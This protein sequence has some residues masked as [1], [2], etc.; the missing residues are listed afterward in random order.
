MENN[1]QEFDKV[2]EL[3]INSSSIT[4]NGFN[5]ANLGS[6]TEY[7]NVF[8]DGL[9]Q[10]LQ[11]EDKKENFNGH[12]A[13]RDS[14]FPKDKE[15]VIEFINNNADLIDSFLDNCLNGNQVHWNES[16]QKTI[17]IYKEIYG[18]DIEIDD[19]GIQIKDIINADAG[20]SFEKNSEWVKPWSVKYFYGM[21]ATQN[22]KEVRD[23]D[24][25]IRILTNEN[26]LQKTHKLFKKYIRLLMPEY[27]RT[28][29]IE[30]LDRNFWVIG[31]VLS[32]ILAFLFDDDAKLKDLFKGMLDEIVQLWQNLLFLW[33][34]FILIAQ[35]EKSEDIITIVVPVNNNIIHPFVNFDNFNYDRFDNINVNN[36]EEELKTICSH[37][38]YLIDQY[39]D[40][41]LIIIPELRGNSYC[42]NY[43]SDVLYPGVIFVDRYHQK[44]NAIIEEREYIH[45]YP[46]LDVED[47]N[48]GHLLKVHFYDSSGKRLT[49]G[50]HSYMNSPWAVNEQYCEYNFINNYNEIPKINKEYFAAIR[51]QF[52]NAEARI[53]DEELQFSVNIAFYDAVKTLYKKHFTTSVNQDEIYS[54]TFELN[55]NKIECNNPTITDENEQI[56]NKKCDIGY[57]WYKG[58]LA[59]IS[60]MIEIIPEGE[61][62]VIEKIFSN[63]THEGYINKYESLSEFL[64]S[65]SE[66]D[67]KER[68]KGYVKDNA[69]NLANGH[70]RILYAKYSYHYRP[71]G[72]QGEQYLLEISPYISVAVR[73]KD[74]ELS[75]YDYQYKI[76]D[77]TGESLH[78][79]I[80]YP[81]VSSSFDDS[82]RSST[83]L[84]CQWDVND[85]LRYG[86]V[87][88]P[89]NNLISQNT[90]TK[91]NLVYGARCRE[92]NQ[93]LKIE[94]ANGVPYLYNYLLLVQDRA[95]AGTYTNTDDSIPYS[96]NDIYPYYY[97]CRVSDY[98]KYTIIANVKYNNEKVGMES[99]DD[100]YFWAEESDN[101]GYLKS[102]TS[103]Q[104]PCLRTDKT[105]FDIGKIESWFLNQSPR[106]LELEEEVE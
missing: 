106:P 52:S 54:G 65:L 96:V 7:Q 27:E 26:N 20:N 71:A 100:Y 105:E 4:A 22:Y 70:A 42:K 74:G 35:K 57:G 102:D 90:T 28:V 79:N 19:T 6:F 68:W 85:S 82:V 41:S 8:W 1:Y 14:M 11:N 9:L 89:N 31:H 97:E 84:L 104:N 44:T 25:I 72:T 86:K 10:F 98:T 58:E 77:N 69:S 88:K 87:Y 67:E 62:V 38:T 81:Y 95:C 63:F 83:E 40:S 73:N 101:R 17:N 93:G 56:L 103:A 12:F 15:S 59:T 76:Q 51:T 61:A 78:R 33:V 39:R 66:I 99:D 3:L 55:N 30:D 75:T 49:I 47:L 94:F 32:G 5:G 64:A 23:G 34:G 92:N 2:M 29:E 16:L 60:C 18:D 13:I 45:Y 80:H 91:G 24:K 36:L 50:R 48:N 46:F 37:L 53:N 21:E 43:Y